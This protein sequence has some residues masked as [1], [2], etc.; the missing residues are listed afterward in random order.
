MAGS[1]DAYRRNSESSRG[2]GD[3]DGGSRVHVLARSGPRAW[4]GALGLLVLALVLGGAFGIAT[5]PHAGF[6][7]Q[8]DRVVVVDAQGSAARSGLLAGD[9]IL[10]PPDPHRALRTRPAGTPLPVEIARGSERRTLVLRAAPPHRREE[11]HRLVQTIVAAACASLGLLAASKRRDATAE[12]FGAFALAAATL[13][14]APLPVALGGLA[15]WI[16]LLEDLAQVALGP[17][18]AHFFLRFPHLSPRLGPALVALLYAPAA[19]LA[20]AAGLEPLG[21]LDESLR[22][23]LVPVAGVYLAATLL[24]ATAR[25]LYV[26]LHARRPERRRLLVI[27][28][29]TLVA[30]A[31]V[32]AGLFLAATEATA[33]WH[34]ELWA[35]V[36]FLALPAAFSYAIVRYRVLDLRVIV[37][38]GLVLAAATASL[39]AG[40]GAVLLAADRAAGLSREAPWLLALLAAVLTLGLAAGAPRLRHWVERWIAPT[41]EDRRRRARAYEERLGTLLHEKRVL[42]SVLE[43]VRDLFDAERVAFHRFGDERDRLVLIDEHG[44]SRP[45]SQV[46]FLHESL[47]APLDDARRVLDVDEIAALAPPAIRPAVLHRMEDL[48]FE[49]L[50]PVRDGDR[51]FGFLSVGPP[52][53]GT[54]YGRPER[55]TLARLAVQTA[56]ALVTAQAHEDAVTRERLAHDLEMARSIQRRL[57]PKAPPLRLEAEFRAVTLSCEAVGG[58]F[59]DYFE[60]PDGRVGFAVGDVAGKG[61]GAALLM[62]A[63]HSSLRAAA[64]GGIPP[65]AVLRKLN[66][67]LLDRN[68]SGRFVC[69]LYAVFD[70]A[71]RTVRLANAGIEPPI[72]APARGPWRR[73]TEGG[74][75]LGVSA[76]AGYPEIALALAPGDRLLVHTDGVV[77]GEDGAAAAAPEDA[78]ALMAGVLREG[79]PALRDALR[80]LLD[81][82]GL[83]PGSA[84]ADDATLLLLHVW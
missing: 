52:R 35:P 15:P 61:I 46:V 73:L 75:V 58:D 48:G 51:V 69:L 68:E 79:A 38:R 7:I 2:G 16:T 18:L 5:A 63:L 45:A 64:E 62:A 50:A 3:R 4:L 43:N 31:P 33:T 77:D 11:A 10:A 21:V 84:P 39:A 49:L 36:F 60:Y 71:T 57:L 29:G 59:Y 14:H 82:S 76:D 56:R 80:R 66:L 13:F 37:R 9:R 6:T 41:W 28:A 72:L 83:G 81:R 19:C 42:A 24:L 17:L 70:P 26:L 25:F 65:S 32:F 1:A 22:G 67:S 8:G 34:I 53:D 78:A 27:L 23:I 40:F 44:A 54:H 20:L 74:L 30:L 47:R 12:L 55:R